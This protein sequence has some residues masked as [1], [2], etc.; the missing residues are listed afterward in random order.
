[1]LH[2]PVGANSFGLTTPSWGT[3]RPASANGTSVTPGSG[4]YGSYKQIGSDL[5]F[6][7]Y[8][9]LIN[10]NT[11][12]GS[13]ASRNTVVTIGVDES[14]GTS[15]TDRIPDLL[16]GGVSAYTVSGG[17]WFYFPMFIPAGAAVAA[18]ASGSVTTAIRVGAVFMNKPS[19]PSMIRKGSFVEAIGISGQVGT[20][21]TPGTASEGAWTSIGTTT[22][23]LW[24]WQVA[25]QLTTA[26]TSWVA[27]G[28]HVDLAVGDESNKD[29][30]ISDTLIIT[31]TAEAMATLPITAGVEWDV[32]AGSTLYMRAQ[33]S[34]ALDTAYTA[35][36]YG[37]GG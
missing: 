9:I 18:K 15:Y 26:D 27:N 35:A 22:S 1:M 16:A 20:S 10:I 3:T 5:S 25:I 6:D 13:N 19:N 8:G 33:N 2:V 34:G 28:I 30:I 36:A 7:A 12:S 14:G 17:G 32:P 4:A 31:T 29:V 24:W 11:N 23:R 37:C 21:I